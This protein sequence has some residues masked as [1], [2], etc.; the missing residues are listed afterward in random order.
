VL[1]Q[2]GHWVTSLAVLTDGR[3]AS[4]DEDGQITLWPNDRLGEPEVLRQ[5]A[6]VRSLVA[7]ADG[8]LVSDD[9]EGHVEV[10]LIGEEQRIHALCL[11]GGRSL[12]SP[13]C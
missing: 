9:E 13:A 5:S 2:D 3:L 10:W 8:R 4:G 11:R 1:R 6:P 12:T 7:L